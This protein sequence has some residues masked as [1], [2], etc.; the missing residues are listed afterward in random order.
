MTEVS[1]NAPQWLEA[2]A[3]FFPLSNKS[4]CEQ[5]AI[6]WLSLEPSGCSGLSVIITTMRVAVSLV[7]S[8][9]RKLL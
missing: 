3:P 1:V 7:S 5:Y 2:V 6:G 9:I 8:L 4:R